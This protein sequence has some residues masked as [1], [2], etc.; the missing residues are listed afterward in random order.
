MD[1]PTPS[2]QI[3]ADLIDAASA[4][5]ERLPWPAAAL[6][7]LGIAVLLWIGVGAVVS[8]LIG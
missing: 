3:H 1:R 8:R 6:V 5:R 2:R 7:I 4:P